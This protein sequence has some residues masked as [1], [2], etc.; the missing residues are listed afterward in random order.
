MPQFYNS[1]T[2]PALDGFDGSGS[3]MVSASSVYTNIAND[4]FPGE[5]D[6]VVFGFCISDCSGTGSNTNGF[7]AANVMEGIKTYNNGEFACNGGGKFVSCYLHSHFVHYYFIQ[8]SYESSSLLFL[9]T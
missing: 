4:L 3:G 6:K 5:P 2:R 7:Q 8:S 9:T 1:I